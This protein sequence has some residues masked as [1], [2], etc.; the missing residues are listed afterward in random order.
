VLKPFPV[1]P[2]SSIVVDSTRQE[3]PV[4]R[5]DLAARGFLKIHHAESLFRIGYDLGDLWEP[6]RECTDSAQ[7]GDVRAPGQILKKGPAVMGKNVD[8]S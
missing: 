7:R 1:G 4:D 3:R 6:F 8:S 2:E 5:I